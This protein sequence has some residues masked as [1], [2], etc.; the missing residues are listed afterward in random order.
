MDT[1]REDATALAQRLADREKILLAEDEAKSAAADLRSILR[2]PHQPFSCNIASET[3]PDTGPRR[4][5]AAVKRT[6]RRC[7]R[8]PDAGQ[9]LCGLHAM[10][11]S[12]VDVFLKKP[13]LEM[14]A[15][16]QQ[17]AHKS[18]DSRIPALKL[19]PL[20]DYV[21]K[22]NDVTHGM[23]SHQQMYS[24]KSEYQWPE[25][26]MAIDADATTQLRPTTSC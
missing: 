4:C 17:L 23:H 3:E 8:T 6:S 20:K 22:V 21:R 26:P 1:R 10:Q 25:R 12:S 18:A 7:N 9:R 24:C 5:A 19:G 11:H 13:W 2:V 16:R 15:S 14:E